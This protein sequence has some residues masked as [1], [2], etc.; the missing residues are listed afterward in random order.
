MHRAMMCPDCRDVAKRAVDARGY[1]IDHPNESY[2]GVRVVDES[3]ESTG[4]EGDLGGAFGST[5]L[6]CR[7]S[8][9]A[10]ATSASP[11][12]PPIA[13]PRRRGECGHRGVCSRPR[14]HGAA[15]QW[16]QVVAAANPPTPARTRSP[17]WACRKIVPRVAV[18]D[19]L[20]RATQ[21]RGLC[22]AGRVFAP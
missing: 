12:V 15:Q 9:S 17:P 11:S 4:R 3:R 22:S 14:R 16:D 6:I 7:A 21:R 1:P 2:A 19:R 20:G 10:C 18:R 5:K 8:S 13:P